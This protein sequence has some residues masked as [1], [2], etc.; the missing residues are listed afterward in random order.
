MH[1]YRQQWTGADELQNEALCCCER[2]RSLIHSLYYIVGWVCSL[3]TTSN[4]FFLGTC[5]PLSAP[6]ALQDMLG[7]K[8]SLLFS[9]QIFAFWRTRDV[10]YFTVKSFISGGKK[11]SGVTSH[12][13]GRVLNIWGDCLNR[14][15]VT[16]LHW[17]DEMRHETGLSRP[18]LINHMTAFASEWLIKAKVELQI[19]TY[20]YIT[21]CKF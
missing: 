18:R 7:T 4:T 17:W 10:P 9:S 16:I 12:T 6:P 8:L 2:K 3:S 20:L 5:L 1:G 15:P 21:F 11:G 13:E 14:H 19:P